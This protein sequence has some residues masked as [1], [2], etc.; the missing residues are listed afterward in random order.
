MDAASSSS[1][2]RIGERVVNANFARGHP[3]DYP[4]RLVSAREWKIQRVSEVA[5]LREITARIWI[6]LA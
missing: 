2:Y 4:L 5:V 3:G 6:V 1:R